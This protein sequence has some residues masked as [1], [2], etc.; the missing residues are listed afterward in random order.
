[1]LRAEGLVYGGWPGHLLF[2]G[3]HL[4]IHPG[5]TRVQGGDGSGKSTLLRLLAG[6]LPA[7]GGQLWVQGVALA[8][9]PQAYRQQVFWADPL[10]TAHDQTTV[11]DYFAALPGHYPR[12]DAALLAD[13]ADS[14][15]LTPHQHK[16]LYMLSAGT[17][18]KVWLAAAFAAG[19]AVTLLDDPL[20]A[21]DHR[22]VELVNALLEEAAGHSTRAWVV[23][24]YCEQRGVAASTVDLG[25]GGGAA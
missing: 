20:A 24:G 15:A 16:P 19:A 13:L 18:R 2:T 14:L 11:A 21:L 6:A 3:L 12:L 7:Q 8:T 23:A 9:Q 17:K 22:S 1:M 5:L 25:D 4:T 10:S